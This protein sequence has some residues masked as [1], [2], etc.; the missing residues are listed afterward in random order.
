MVIN[1]SFCLNTTTAISTTLLK[2]SCWI[3]QI[4]SQISI[5]FFCQL[6]LVAFFFFNT[7]AC[8][9]GKFFYKH[10]SLLPCCHL[11]CYQRLL[12]KAGCQAGLLMYPSDASAVCVC[13]CVWKM[14]LTPVGYSWWI[15][16]VFRR[17][18]SNG[19]IA[20]KLESFR[21]NQSLTIWL[22]NLPPFLEMG[23][24]L[25]S[26]CGIGIQIRRVIHLLNPGVFLYRYLKQYSSDP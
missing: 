1:G 17:K 2:G 5:F 18:D 9:S 20:M 7:F 19:L 25:Q 12:V 10:L 16:I 3:H 15:P 26:D 13:V 8:T 4:V 22:T 11:H 23:T 21:D 24:L 14:A 6:C